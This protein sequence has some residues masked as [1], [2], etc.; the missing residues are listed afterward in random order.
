MDQISSQDERGRSRNARDLLKRVD[1][2]ILKWFGHREREEG[3]QRKFKA[4]VDGARGRDEPK[5]RY[6]EGVT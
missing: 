2:R 6:A 5:R 4:E 1:Q 3:S